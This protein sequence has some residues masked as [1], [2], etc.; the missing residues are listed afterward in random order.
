MGKPFIIIIYISD[1]TYSPCGTISGHVNTAQPESVEVICV[2][3]DNRKFTSKC[4]LCIC[5]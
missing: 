3:S 2:A 4:L 5:M 1:N